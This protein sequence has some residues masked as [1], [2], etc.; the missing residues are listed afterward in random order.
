MRLSFFFSLLALLALPLSGCVV[1]EN[2][3][4]L[5]D[6][7]D[8]DDDT[9]ADDDDDTAAPC[10]DPDD[11]EN[12][13]VDEPAQWDVAASFSTPDGEDAKNLMITLCG[14]SC[15]N[16][17]TNC[18]G[19]VYFPFADSDTYV[20]EPLF[21]PNLEFDRWARSFDFV[22]FDASGDRLDLS[23]S[24]Y[25]VPLVEEIEPIGT[26]EVERIF[27][28]GLEVRFNSEAIELPFGP[29]LATL[30]AVEIPEA[31]YPT[32]GLLDWTAMR[33]W[34]LAIW[35]MEIAE[36]EGFQ[37]VAPL[38]SP[39]P[40]GAE[41]SFLVAHYEYGIVSGTFEVFPAEIAAD[42]MSI[43]TPSDAGIDRTTM[44]IAAMRMP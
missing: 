38:T 7:D 39:V 2:P 5:D 26:G 34:A 32:G 27:S 4:W 41:V 6:D 30:G 25:I 10:S 1:L 16:E 15:Y 20:L 44:W 29:K 19:V 37:V 40:D 22:D 24:P 43:T 42:R 13:L 18:E 9:S 35:E 17:P 14:D 23:A 8:D 3:S 33:V 12:W 21:A 11:P 31:E 36:A 28:S